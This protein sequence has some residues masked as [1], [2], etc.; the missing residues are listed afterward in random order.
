MLI[1]Y[2]D[3]KKVGTYAWEGK[4]EELFCFVFYLVCRAAA[5]GME[6]MEKRRNRGRRRF[7]LQCRRRM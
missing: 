1:A 3:C 6:P 7:L 5:Q 2:F 4:K